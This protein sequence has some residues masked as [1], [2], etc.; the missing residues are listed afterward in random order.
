MDFLADFIDCMT[1]KGCTPADIAEIMADDKRRRYRLADEAKGKRSGGY[2]LKTNGDYAVGWFRSFREGVTHKYISKA[3]REFTAEERS[4]WKKKTEA[5]RADHKRALETAQATAAV[6]AR[7]LWKRASKEGESPYLQKKGINKLHGARIYKGAV[8]VPISIGGE[9]KSLQ[10]IM[11]GKKRMLTNGEIAGGYFGIAR[12]LDDFSIIFICE[13][14]STGAT[15]REAMNMP[16][17]CAMFAG[18]LEAVAVAIRKKYP[19]ARIV[20]AADN[21]EFTTNAKGEP[22]NV[23]IIK[24]QAAAVKI[25][26]AAVIYPEFAPEHQS[27]ENNDFND[28]FRLYGYNYVKDRISQALSNAGDTMAGGGEEFP[29]CE[30]VQTP[31]SSHHLEEPAI[32][33]YSDSLP[34]IKTLKDDENWEQLLITDG[35]GNNKPSSL[36]NAMLFLRFHSA[37]KGVFSYDEFA[38]QIVIPVCPPWERSVRFSVKRLDDVTIINCAAELENYGCSVGIDKTKSAIQAVAHEARF[39]PAREY[40][41]SLQWDG[42]YR[43]DKWLTYYLGCENESADY[44]S[45]IGKKWLTAAVTRVFSPGCKFD[46]VL[47]IEGGQG[48][49][50]STVLRTLATFGKDKERSYFT[51]GVS[52]SQIQNKDTMMKMQGSLIIELSELSGFSKK[53]DEEIKHW[54]VVQDDEARLPFGHTVSRFPRQ[55]VLAATTNKHDYLKD[56]TGNRRYWPVM[57]GTHIDMDALKQDREQLWAEAVYWHKQGLYLGPTAAEE[58]LANV[59]REK[60]LSQDAWTDEVLQK[61]EDLRIER[62]LTGSRGLRVE[63]IMAKMNMVLRDRDD[64]AVR[65]INGI[66]Q[67]N[68]FEKKSIWNSEKD[69]T[70]RMWIKTIG[71]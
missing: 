64:R 53:E 54:I 17:V 16:V 18:N 5:A 48:I 61:A 68:G 26:G 37:F 15:I 67:M 63:D 52:I 19:T 71:E 46:H 6:L 44:L 42:K 8:C 12:S 10:F 34:S 58:K 22:E 65:R 28:A 69:K 60:R 31:A 13:G 4:A 23:G 38:N 43:L 14:F 2:Q 20:F 41:N 66:L 45:F 57:T 59:E 56:P 51:D 35:K 47:V 24:A 29:I 21:D 32:E 40:F 9:I 1:Q 49:G 62:G 27:K 55:F 50:K 33:A 25:G 39:H 36:K 3:K 7:K 30:N 11:L 70:E